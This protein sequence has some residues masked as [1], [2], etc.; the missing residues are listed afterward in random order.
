[1][2][3]AISETNRRRKMQIAYNKEHHITPR[4][5]EKAIQ[6]II[7]HELKPE[8][9]REFVHL[10]NLEDLPRVLAA[11]Q[12]EMKQAAQNLRPPRPEFLLE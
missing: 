12:V 5:I 11:K 8:V 9:T 2:E 6:T 1:M 4:T 10:E 7:D 3:R